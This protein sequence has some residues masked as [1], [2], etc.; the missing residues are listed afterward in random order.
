MRSLRNAV[1]Q[2]RRESL[3]VYALKSYRRNQSIRQR[4]VIG[5]LVAKQ[6]LNNKCHSPFL[7][8]II[9]INIAS[10]MFRI[11]YPINVFMVKAIIIK[12]RSVLFASLRVY[13]LL[14]LVPLFHFQPLANKGVLTSRILPLM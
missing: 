1:P 10:E 6:N 8:P 14:K 11:K 4:L 9:A 12:T 2:L 13:R 3:C 7:L 5:N